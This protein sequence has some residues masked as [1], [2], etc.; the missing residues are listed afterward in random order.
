MDF[1]DAKQRAG[2]IIPGDFRGVDITVRS[3]ETGEILTDVKWVMSAQTF[4]TAARVEDDGTAQL[5]LLKTNYTTFMAVADREKPEGVDYTWFSNPDKQEPI[6]PTDDEATIWLTPVPI[7][8]L[9]A[10]SGTDFGGMLG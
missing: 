2:I 1:V 10:G 9:Y 3:A 8:G 4:P 6:N 5:P 7:Q